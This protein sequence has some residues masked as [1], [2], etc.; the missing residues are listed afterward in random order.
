MR[1]SS[2]SFEVS[3]GDG[4]SLAGEDAAGIDAVQD[5]PTSSSL[6]PHLDAVRVAGWCSRV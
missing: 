4:T 6:V 1:K 2:A 3:G 5:R